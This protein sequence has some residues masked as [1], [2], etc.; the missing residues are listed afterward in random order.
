MYALSTLL[1][2]GAE[3]TLYQAGQKRKHY[4]EENISNFKVCLLSRGY[5]S[6]FTNKVVIK[7]SKILEQ[8]IGS[9]TKR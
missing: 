5:P 4:F 3:K 6:M 1:P 8:K 9:I 2:S 7:G